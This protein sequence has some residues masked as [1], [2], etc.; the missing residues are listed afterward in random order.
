M[1]KR[2]ATVNTVTAGAA[3]TGASI[4]SATLSPTAQALFGAAGVLNAG[5]L[6]RVQSRHNHNGSNALA[7][8]GAYAD[9]QAPGFGAVTINGAV[10]TAEAN[11]DVL[12]RV[13]AGTQLGA[14]G[15]VDVLAYNSNDALADANALSIGGAAFGISIAT[16]EANG[17]TTA[18]HLGGVTQSDAVTVRAQAKNLANADADASG[19]GLAANNGAYSDAEANG[20]VSVTLGTVGQNNPVNASGAIVVEAISSADATADT[21]GLSLGLGS[22]VG[23][24]GASAEASP[25]VAVTVQGGTAM[26]SGT[27]VRVGAYHNQNG[28]DVR[29]QA[30]A[31]GGGLGLAANGTV[32]DARSEADTQVLLGNSTALA[33]TPP[34]P[35]TR[36]TDHTATEPATPTT[37]PAPDSVKVL[38]SIS[39][40]PLTATSPAAATSAPPRM[41]AAVS[42]FRLPTCT[43]PPTPTKPPATAPVKCEP[44]ALLAALTNTPWSASAPALPS[45]RLMRA[46]A[47]ITAVVSES[48]KVT[49]TAPPTP[50]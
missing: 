21:F 29:A 23:V 6:I 17:S 11:A 35:S 19:G 22:A 37:P 1:Y 48:S 40:R 5:G 41:R 45:A 27:G 2:Q 7:D 16:A 42:F 10:P 24:M 13:G 50:T 43:A 15:A 12:S 20:D 47:P 49:P 33:H 31:A 14:G 28:E 3:S 36:P 30:D 44:V 8:H 4:A 39:D 9:A 38:R 32:V 18:D 26:T 46:L 34:T 25:D